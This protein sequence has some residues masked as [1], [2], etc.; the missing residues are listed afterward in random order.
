MQSK[1]T[2][3]RRRFLQGVAAAVAVGQ[4]PI[5]SSLW[6]QTP[7]SSREKLF[8]FDYSDVKLTGGP[9]RD[10][11]DRIHASYR[12]LDEDRLLKVYR[13]RAGLPAPGE[14]MGGWYDAEG[15]GPGQVLGQII[16]G[17]ARFYSQTGDPA[18]QAK[19]ERLVKGFAATIDSEDYWYPSL[20]AS[21]AS[22]AYTLDKILIGTLDAWQFAGIASAL[23]IARRCV[24]GSLRYL[25]RRAYER[26]E[27]P[28]QAVYDETYTLPENLFY[29]WEMSKDQSYREMAKQYLMDKTYFDPLSR[30]E[31]VL[32]GLHAY[33][34]VNAL[35]SA[36]R[37]YLVLGDFKYLEAIRNAWDMIEKTQSFASGGW[38]PNEEF[39]APGKGLLGE[40]LAKT[41]AHFETPCGSY[42]HL[43]LARYLLRVTAEARYGDSLERVLYNTILGVKDPQGDGHVFY[44]SDY[45]RSTQKSY[46]Q[47]KWPCCSGTTPQ[48]VADY[49]ISAYFASEDGI[50]VNLF[51]PSE[52]GW[53]ARGVP[54]K[55]IQTTTYPEADSMEL[56]VEVGA[57]IEFS[58]FV[59]IPGWL[60]SPAQLAVNGKAVS[61]AAEPRT[62]AEIRRR[63]QTNDTV[64]I[65][66][67]FS[68]WFQPIDEQHPNTVALM[69]G[70]LTLVALEPPLELPTRSVATATEGLRP[71]AGS[72]LTFEAS[73][74]AEKLLF[75]PF[76]RIRDEVYSTYIQHNLS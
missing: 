21:T 23:D 33:S 40:S 57:P 22:A 67:P 9:L 64:Q 38:G 44:Y 19:V 56:R 51:T 73:R 5:P 72:P 61:V 39:V 30:G 15:F 16:S 66:I 48:V 59:R 63:W 17:L 1:R 70:P 76:Y 71:I 47:D 55:I 10:Q 25:P 36:A 26:F 43:K 12:S 50:Y 20:K 6:T 74:K 35:C 24:K 2:I 34:H 11:L 53:K 62:F 8:L 18:T 54:A 7:P 60:K 68:F 75:V 29:L 3:C 52:V 13:Q 31:N 69:W 27:A 4:R 65:R 32:P 42:A 49:A 28:K 14:D 46:M 58:I 37:A 41:H 45:H